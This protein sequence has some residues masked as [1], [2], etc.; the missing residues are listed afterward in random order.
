MI[1]GWG[2]GVNLTEPRVQTLETADP[3]VFLLEGRYSLLNQPRSTACSRTPEI[4]TKR[5]RI[6]ASH[7]RDA[8]D[9]RAVSLRFCAA[10]PTG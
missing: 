3:D 8:A 4:I 10:P 2:L 6:A 5:D 7:E 9:I 1:K